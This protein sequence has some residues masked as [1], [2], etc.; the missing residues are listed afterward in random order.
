MTPSIFLLFLFF[1]S[2]CSGKL[3]GTT[4]SNTS[5]WQEAWWIG[6]ALSFRFLEHHYFLSVGRKF[7]FEDQ[8]VFI[9]QGCQAILLSFGVLLLLLCPLE[10][11]IR[12]WECSTGRV[13]T[14]GACT[15]TILP[16][17]QEKSPFSTGLCLQSNKFKDRIKNAGAE[18]ANSR[19]SE[20]SF[21]WLP[22]SCICGAGPVQMMSRER[23]CWFV[24]ENN[25]ILVLF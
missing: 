5:S 14:M 16:L 2:S 11:H 8:N 22:W 20:G 25:F 24:T 10:F 6:L 1:T 18:I 17:P 15:L 4:Y 9:S 3:A 23:Q 13:R 7:W 21:A 12:C 19:P